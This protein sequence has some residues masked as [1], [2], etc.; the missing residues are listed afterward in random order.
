M[1]YI[2]K[3]LQNVLIG[4]TVYI[5]KLKRVQNHVWVIIQIISPLKIK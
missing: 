1:T 3:G 2:L 5:R 4:T